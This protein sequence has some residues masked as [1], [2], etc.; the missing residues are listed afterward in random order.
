MRTHRYAQRD[1]QLFFSLLRLYLDVHLF[2]EFLDDR[3]AQST[4]FGVAGRIAFIET[5][6]D[7]V[8]IERFDAGIGKDA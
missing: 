3:H 7:R 2:T 4:A 6:K 1:R 5:L 8:D